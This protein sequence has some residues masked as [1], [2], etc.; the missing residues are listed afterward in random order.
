MS[1]RG[2]SGATFFRIQI[3]DGRRVRLCNE[4]WERHILPGHPELTAY[5]INPIPHIEAA[6]VNPTREVPGNRL[7]RDRLKFV[8]QQVWID[9]VGAPCNFHVVVE[10]E[11]PTDGWVVTAFPRL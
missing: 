9:A 6:L 4:T 3:A 11:S 8:G 7:G 10:W 1:R 2:P 5:F